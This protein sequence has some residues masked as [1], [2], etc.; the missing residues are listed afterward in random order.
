MIL[1]HPHTYQKLGFD[2][3]LTHCAQWVANPEAKERLLETKPTS[4]PDVLLPEL[5]RVNEYKELIEFDDPM[6]GD[7]FISLD[8]IAAKLSTEGDWLSTREL[9]QLLQW[10]KTIKVV[11]TYLQSRKERY[12]GLALLVHELPFSQQMIGMIDGVLDRHGNVSD[13]A[14]EELGKIRRQLVA[15]SDGLRQTLQRILRKAQEKNWTQDKEITIRNDR[16]V[17]PVKS[18]SRSNIDG[19]VHD[20]S[21]SG[22]TVYIEPAEALSLNNKIRELQIREY[23]EMVRILQQITGKLRG[24]HTEIEGFREVMIRLE[25]IRAKAKLAIQLSASLPIIEPAQ[26]TLRLREAYYPPLWLKHQVLSREKKPI[27]PFNLELNPSKRIMV[28]SGP[29]AGGKSVTLKS[30]GLLQLMLQSGF[31]ISVEETSI[32]PLFKALF[33]EIGDE[34]S[35]EADLSTYTSRLYYW[36]QMGD[37][38][39]KDSLFLID[40][41]GSGTDPKQGGAIA[42]SFLDRFVHQQSVGVITTHYG[43]LKDYAEVTPGVINGAMQFD[44]AELKPTY[45]LME[46]VP[47]R[48]YAFEMAKRVGVHPT[49]LKRARKRL[50]TEEIDTERL[51]KELEKKN[52]E[53]KRK[54]SEVKR[55]EDRLNQLVKKN[56]EKDANSQLERKHILRDAKQEARTLI[57]QANREIERTIREIRESQ[58]EK[59]LTR[60]L[61]KELIEQMPE[62]QPT[63][64]ELAA[65]S[66]KARKLKKKKTRQSSPQAGLV[67]LKEKPVDGDWV[68]LKEGQTHGRLVDIQG[69]KG[70]VEA[71]GGIRLQVNL[72]DLVKIQA[73]KEPAQQSSS[74][75][76]VSDLPMKNARLE[77]DVMGKRADQALKE[78][79]KLIDEARYAGLHRVRIL[80]GKGTGALRESIRMFLKDLDFVTGMA[81]APVDEGGAGW[82]IVDLSPS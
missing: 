21:Q 53:L 25:M 52:T 4:D 23:N 10:L 67:V 59:E 18:E 19:F 61:R 37:K 20:M 16:L 51:L 55:K 63:L 24:H 39:D 33:L 50:G 7:H 12:P 42:E 44:T 13:S 79:S 27:V 36:R 5:Q 26:K 56:E 74:V 35:I 38:L 72:K 29:N 73:P 54:L 68:K 78:V 34:Q 9:N 17:I 58:A 22:G 80:H 75:T 28:I 46:G 14:S 70:F 3:I 71:L 65:S 41:F 81:D 66:A 69:K 64:P 31:L 62:D 49:I 47:G 40:E 57:Q 48:S 30:L 43:N 76:L 82:T 11:R 2:Q 6:P 77:L 15:S 45:I 8:R 60:K 32:F 1:H